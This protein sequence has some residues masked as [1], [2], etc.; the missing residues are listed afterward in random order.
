MSAG[1]PKRRGLPTRRDIGGNLRPRY[2]S[3]DAFADVRR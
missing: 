3:T 2:D 1:R